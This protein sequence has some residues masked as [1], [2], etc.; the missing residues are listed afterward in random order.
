M[1]RYWCNLFQQIWIVSWKRRWQQTASVSFSPGLQHEA[2]RRKTSN[3]NSTTTASIVLHRDG[4]SSGGFVSVL[5]TQEVLMSVE[6]LNEVTDCESNK[7]TLFLMLT[8][9]QAPGL[10][11]VPHLG[12]QHSRGWWEGPTFQNTSLR[13][14]FGSIRTDTSIRTAPSCLQP[15]HQHGPESQLSVIPPHRR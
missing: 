4:A 3:Q 8:E 6:M 1:W 10:K 13:Q 9:L 2:P 7:H 14:Q 15:A 5:E 11:T 12:P